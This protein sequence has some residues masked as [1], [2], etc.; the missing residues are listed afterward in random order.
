MPIKKKPQVKISA[1]PKSSPESDESSVPKEKSAVETK[2]DFRM[3]M[4]VEKELEDAQTK[5]ENLSQI[6]AKTKS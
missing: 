1:K 3:N 6:A 5:F 2:Q 4:Q